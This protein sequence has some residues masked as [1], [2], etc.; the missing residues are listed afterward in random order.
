MPE[1][2]LDIRDL[3]GLRIILAMPE[4]PALTDEWTWL[5]VMTGNSPQWIHDGPPRWLR[6]PEMVWRDPR[7][8]I[9]VRGNVPPGMERSAH[10]LL[11]GGRGLK[12]P[13]EEPSD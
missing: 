5:E 9:T 3:I 4:G 6:E 13:P 1:D 7:L 2:P 10:T 11:L 12:L 8:P